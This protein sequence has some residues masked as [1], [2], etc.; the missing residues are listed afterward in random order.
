MNEMPKT[1]LQM[2]N[3]PLHPSPL[4]QSSLVII[5]AQ[6]EYVTGKLP[7]AGVETAISEIEK[8]LA[9][10]RRESM[11]VFHV[12]HHSAP[13]RALFD[14]D[15]PYA[16]IVPPLAPV[17]GEQTVVKA[18]PNAFAGTDLQARLAASGRR[19]IILAG[20]MTHMCVSATAR[21]A[22]DFGYRTSAA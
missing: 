17:E 1:L 10:A 15:G 14:P 3:A 16:A 13:G 5:D 11:P 22:L 12:V 4:G 21:A 9:L 18:L 20:F 8:L 6:L 7:L 2:A 19:E